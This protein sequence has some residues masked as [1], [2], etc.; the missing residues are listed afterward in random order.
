MVE[1]ALRVLVNVAFNQP[2]TAQAV[3][4]ARG[5]DSVCGA[6]AAS[7]LLQVND[8]ERGA[9][10]HFISHL[11]SHANL[12]RALSLPFPRR[13]RI[14]KWGFFFLFVSFAPASLSLAFYFSSVFFL[15]SNCP[16]CSRP[17]NAKRARPPFPPTGPRHFRSWVLRARQLGQQRAKP[18][19][20][21]RLQRA[22]ALHPGL[23]TALRLEVGWS[24]GRTRSTR[25]SALLACTC[26]DTLQV[27]LFTYI[28][29]FCISTL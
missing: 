11:C 22:T 10:T 15:P 26:R 19:Q 16:F 23:P 4:A 13:L 18:N 29:L 25:D 17:P 7:D 1:Q 9:R 3:I 5:I 21:G 20:R 8:I 24:N 2:Y 28:L 27:S 6:L 12:A 14:Y